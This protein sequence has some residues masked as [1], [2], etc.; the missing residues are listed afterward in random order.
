M[1]GAREQIL[2]GI[3]QSLGRGSLDGAGRAA[4]RERLDRHARHII[5]A[6]SNLDP[7]GQVALFVSKAR[8]VSATVDHVDDL[9]AVPRAVATYLA[10]ENLPARLVQAPG[11]TETGLEW[12]AVPTV[13]VRTGAPE[14]ADDVSLTPAFAGIAETGTL[15]LLSGPESPT[16]LNFLPPTHIVVLRRDQVVGAYEDAWDRLRVARG[17]DGGLPRVVNFITGPSRTGDI[18]QKIELGVHGPLRLHI[19]VVDR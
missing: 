11:L 10:R 4:L 7:P 13:E 15:L 2:A 9:S 18:E 5:P 12:E 8:A 16:T 1:T 19:I 3:R 14:K 17:V 6:R